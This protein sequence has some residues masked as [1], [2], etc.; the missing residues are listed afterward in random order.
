MLPEIFYFLN[1]IFMRVELDVQLKHI[2]YR[3]NKKWEI[4]IL[5]RTIIVV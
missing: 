5:N 4:K 1:F 2:D 3:T